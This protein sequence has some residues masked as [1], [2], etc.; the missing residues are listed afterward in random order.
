[1][2]LSKSR[3]LESRTCH[4]HAFQLQ[5][6]ATTCYAIQVT[7]VIYLDPSG[8]NS[9]WVTTTLFW[10]FWSLKTLSWPTPVLASCFE[11]QKDW[12]FRKDLQNTGPVKGQWQECRGRAYTYCC[13][14]DKFVQLFMINVPLLHFFSCLHFL[15]SIL[16]TENKIVQVLAFNYMQHLL[17]VLKQMSEASLGNYFLAFFS[18]TN[19]KH[20]FVKSASFC[21]LSISHS[22]LHS[23]FQGKIPL[24]IS[25]LLFCL[26][27]ITV[28]T[29]EQ[30]DCNYCEP[31]VKFK[32]HYWRKKKTR[33]GKKT[34]REY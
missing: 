25:L 15:P 32:R 26:F 22:F 16:F 7:S 8:C 1:M 23:E 31:G 6:S 30:R 3:E 10:T 12:S 9:I 4:K 29:G 11:H 21:F 19:F 2:M 33:W 13:A 24:C 18:G 34:I 14:P 27:W 5:S 28:T 17:P 20:L